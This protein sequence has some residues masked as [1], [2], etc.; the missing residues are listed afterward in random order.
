MIAVPEREF[1]REL[2]RIL[3]PFSLPDSFVRALSDEEY[4]LFLESRIRKAPVLKITHRIWRAFELRDLVVGSRGAPEPRWV[5]SDVGRAYARRLQC[6]DDPFRSQHQQR[7]EHIITMAGKP[8]RVLLNEA[9]TSL[10]W[11]SRRKTSSG[12]PMISKT[13]LEA[14]ERLQRDFTIA[15]M[16]PRVTTDWNFSFGASAAGMR[17]RDPAD[18][19]DMVL[20]ARQRLA[21]AY[22]AVGTGL[23][24]VLTEICCHQRGLEEI[25]RQFGW[26]QRSGKVVLQIALDRL[27]EHYN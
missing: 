11:L 22:K 24:D 5:L 8:H 6:L 17:P 12:Q 9:E 20:A 4:A 3:R 26:P 1:D 14:G 10:V 18:V 23:S 19:S 13:Q 27:V 7:A 21:N 2:R 15:Q 16:D 25:E